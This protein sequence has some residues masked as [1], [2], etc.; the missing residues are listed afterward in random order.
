MATY[1][2]TTGQGTAGHPSRQ[3]SPY[4][5]ERTVSIA[6]VVSDAGANLSNGDILQMIDVPAETVVIYAGAEVLTAITGTTVTFDVGL[7]SGGAL[8]VFIDG[9]STT[10]GVKALAQPVAGAAEHQALNVT[11]DT[12]DITLVSGANDISA[13]VIRVWAIL[14]D[15]SGINET[16]LDVAVTF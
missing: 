10:A 11:A 6:Q 9:A 12:L 2:R 15:V 4:V 13:G 14:C 7:L 8:D 1:D 3:R 16:D 5:V